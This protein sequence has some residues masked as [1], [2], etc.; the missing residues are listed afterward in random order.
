MRINR[1]KNIFFGK[2]CVAVK[3]FF[4]GGG[5]SLMIFLLS[6]KKNR[7]IIYYWSE[8]KAKPLNFLK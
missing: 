3:I 8:R 4:E 6:K 5:R 1:E 2:I 7:I